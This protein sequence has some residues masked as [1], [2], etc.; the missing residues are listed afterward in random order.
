MSLYT[1]YRPKDWDEL[2]GQDIVRTILQSSIQSGKIGHAYIFTG[3]RGTGKTSSA[4]IFA[5]AINCENPKNG[6]PCHECK[7]CRDFDSNSFLDVIEMDAASHTQ[8]DNMRELIEAMQTLP[9]Q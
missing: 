9:T 7:N 5:K 6:N 3:S 8:V 4:R 2:I 1:K